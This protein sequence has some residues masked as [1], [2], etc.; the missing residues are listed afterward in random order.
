MIT[1]YFK[2]SELVCPHVHQKYGDFAWNFFDIRLLILEEAIHS[3]LG[4]DFN[5]LINNWEEHG[6]FSQRGL[7][8][9]LCQLMQDVY[10]GGKLFM[11]PHAFGKAIDQDF[12]GM[13]AEEG[14]QYLIDNKNFWPYPF[15]LESSVLWIH[16]DVYS[17]GSNGKVILFNA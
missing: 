11:D 3:R 16:L 9:P 1:D 14:R 7:R 17:D 13:T 15:R 12:Q 6:T 4:K 5:I 2:L 10:K 8:C